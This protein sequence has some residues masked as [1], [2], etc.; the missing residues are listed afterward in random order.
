MTMEGGKS[1]AGRDGSRL[2]KGENNRI[3]GVWCRAVLCALAHCCVNPARADT[4]IE[5][6]PT[7]WRLQDYLDGAVIT[8]YTGS[9]CFQGQLILPAT[10][11]ADSRNR[12][13]AIIT[14]AKVAGKAVGVYFVNNSGTCTITN[15]YLKEQ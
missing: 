1:S 14:T 5:A 13:W 7:A 9:S 15:F 6:V 12:Y 2:R 3:A 11:S 4:M 10:V 8:W